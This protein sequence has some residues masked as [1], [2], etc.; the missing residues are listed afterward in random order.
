M[1]DAIAAHY[2]L[3]GEADRLAGWSLERARTEQLVARI[4]PKAAADVLDVGGGPGRYAAWLAGL[5]HRVTLID[6]VSLH[7]E[8]SS[9]AAAGRWTSLLGDARSLDFVDAS[10]D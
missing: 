2:A 8:Q 5:G 3:G 4:L 6:P 10:F 1:D 9:A 7:V